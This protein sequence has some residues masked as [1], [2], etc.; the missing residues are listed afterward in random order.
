MTGSASSSAA[1][2]D[3]LAPAPPA[4]VRALNDAPV[5]PERG[6]V[7][8]WM[9]A[10]RRSRWSFA[11]DQDPCEARPTGS[12]DLEVALKLERVESVVRAEAFTKAHGAVGLAEVQADDME[13]LRA[14]GY[15]E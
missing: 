13:R 4:R 11:L 12:D 1:R 8:Y 10:S 2:W 9:V 7:L 6:Y 3:S 15:V 14:L 5:R